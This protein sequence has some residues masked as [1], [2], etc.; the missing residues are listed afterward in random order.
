LIY[1]SSRECTSATIQ[2]FVWSGSILIIT[3]VDIFKSAR[4]TVGGC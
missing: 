3:E 1:V 4:T 2:E